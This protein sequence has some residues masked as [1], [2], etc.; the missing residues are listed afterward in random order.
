MA[1]HNKFHIVLFPLPAQGHITPFLSLADR[2]LHHQNFSVTFVS[3]SRNVK[4]INSSLS[5]TSRLQL[6]SLPF[7]P[8][9]YGLPAHAESPADVHFSQFVTFFK[10]M[11]SN[12]SAFDDFISSVVTEGGDSTPN[13]IISDVFFAWTVKIARKY[14][15]MHSVFVTSGAF[16][17]SV[18]SSLWIYQ[19]HCHTYE[20]EFRLPNFREIVLDQSQTQKIFLAADGTDP[21]VDFLQRQASFIRKTDMMLSNTVREFEY[22]GL[23]MLREIFEVPVY[24]VGPLLGPTNSHT[25]SDTDTHIMNWL[26][27]QTPNSV[28]FIS[29]GSQIR[30][31]GKQ[32]MELALGLEA[33]GYPFIWVVRPPLEFDMKEEFRAEWLPESFEERMK[34]GNRGLIVTGWAPQLMILS[35]KS[36]GAFLSHCGWNSVLESLSHGVRIIGWP[37]MSDQFYN[38]K[39][40]DEVVGVSLE[41]ARGNYNNARVDK[42]KVKEVVK[43]VM[44][45]T[46][47]GSDMKK[48]AL[49][50]QSMMKNAWRDEGGSSAKGFEEFLEAIG[51]IADNST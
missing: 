14:N 18:E 49:E 7:S 15:V 16:G 23:R 43:L 10:A 40:L 4:S 31:Q 34:E 50:I 11:E 26:D 30:L 41:V 37:C 8:T 13:C 29:F 36:T 42:E 25:C 39:M 20:F 27:S 9:E 46:E 45:E 24:P 28:L 21:W 12:R 19:P 2:L 51:F 47:K 3:N 44:G 1:N 35:H 32:M 5:P 48:R 22:T 38:S 6:Y 17:F 33:A